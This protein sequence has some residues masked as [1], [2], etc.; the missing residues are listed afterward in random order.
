MERLNRTARG[1][2]GVL[3]FAAL[4]LAGA[5]ALGT[6]PVLGR[7]LM[8]LSAAPLLW[9]MIAGRPPRPFH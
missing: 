3:V 7:W 6:D 4:L 8:G 5:V 2:N 1:T 9:A